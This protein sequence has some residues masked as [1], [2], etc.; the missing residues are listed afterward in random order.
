MLRSI[1]P[2]ISSRSLILP[3]SSIRSFTSLRSFRCFNTS[4]NNKSTLTKDYSQPIVPK[5]DITKP[6]NDYLKDYKLSEL[7]SYFCIGLV[8]LNKPI[9]NL[10][11][12]IF[13]FVP[14]PIIKALVYKVYCGGETMK[15]LFKVSD[16]LQSRGINNMMLSLTIEAA[17]GNEVV[18]PEY[19]IE[20]TNKSI[21]EFLIPNT[22]E[23]IKNSQD[24]NSIPPSYVALKPT[25]FSH[26]AAK[27][28][29]DYQTDKEFDVLVDRI[30][31]IIKTINDA[32]IS[33]QKQY[34]QRIAPIVVGVI[35]AEKHD[36]QNGVYELQRRLYK[37]FNKVDQPVSVVGTLQMYLAESGKLLTLEENL[38]KEGNYRLGL[39]LV[40]GAYIHSEADR[41]VI[42]KTKQ[43][44]D[45]NY[46]QGIT[47]C[48]DNILKQEKSEST[49]GH[50]VI[51][52][53]N[54]ESLNLATDL[55]NNQQSTNKNNIVLGQLFGMADN[56][57]YD[58][59]KDKNVKNVIKY[60]P[61]G[62][63]VETKAYL[64]RRL[65]ENG[66]A[67]KNDTGLNL[68]KD[69]LTTVWKRIF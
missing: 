60:V 29:R 25:G 32:N 51:A 57:T 2:R 7:F 36:L 27:I 35:D 13:P 64:L 15:D 24:I 3:S 5:V 43:D 33:L 30:S 44:T 59:I 31:K 69:V 23:K 19:I 54:S 68:I 45:V 12:K 34:P 63:P 53:H 41:S 48:I 1:P 55:I 38:A 28:L 10:C 61:W 56:I 20:E 6:K 9:L 49:V 58:L 39:K 37:Q 14:M 11:I 22:I 65:E 8:T 67:V 21:N 66:D 4:P 47:Y 17:E 16:R 46:N 40:R 50:L 42:H 52:S 62:P 18:D 26:N